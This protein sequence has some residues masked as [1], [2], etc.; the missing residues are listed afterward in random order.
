MSPLYMKDV[1]IQKEITY[2]RRDVNLLVQ[3]KFKTVTYGH[4]IIKY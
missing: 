4:N 2:G 1:F 3:P